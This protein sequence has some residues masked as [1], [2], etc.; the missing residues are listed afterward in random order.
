[1]IWGMTIK[2]QQAD[3][4]KREKRDAI[5][6]LWYAW[7]PVKLH[8]GRFAWLC[9]LWR[10]S[11]VLGGHWHYSAQHPNPPTSAA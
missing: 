9:Y 3:Y 4:E 11:K 2:E 6:H 8:D 7:H 1:M 10:F 5:P